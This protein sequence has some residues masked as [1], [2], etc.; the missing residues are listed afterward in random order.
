MREPRR[1]PGA[2]GPSSRTRRNGALRLATPFAVAALTALV[3]ALTTTLDAFKLPPFARLAIV[4]GG[5]VLAG[6]IALVSQR[7][8]RDSVRERPTAV[9]G[10]VAPAQ[11]P[12]VIA[13]FTGRTDILARLHRVFTEESAGRRAREW[14]GCVVVSV[15]GPGGVGK[16]ALV[17]RFAHEV[18]GR[19]P[20]GQLYCDLRGAG[21]VR[22][23]AEDVLTGFLLALGVRLTT[24][25]GGLA[26]LQKLWWTWV[27]GRR[28]LIFLDNAQFADQV[29]AIVP[30]EAGCAVLVTSR[31]PLYLRNTLDVRLQQ[32]TEP[33]AVELLARLAG[34]DRVAADAEAAVRVAALCDHLPLAVSICGGR[35]A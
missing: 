5:S 32:F 34:D 18:A 8:V 22:V 11:L 6:L 33:Q 1:W 7:E 14:S 9:G 13:H 35:L 12:P 20:D 4:T 27:K 23:R 21:D 24:D 19:Y 16:S 2:T 31:Q 30:P 26:D 15:H 25:P 28:I 17:T 10:A 29:Q 3:T